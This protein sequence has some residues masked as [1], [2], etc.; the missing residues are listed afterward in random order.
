M[1][2]TSIRISSDTHESVVKARGI[3]EQLFRRRL[4]LDEA[5]Y[6][7]SWLIGFL[8]Q[9][10]RKLEAQNIIEI[11][12]TEKGSLRLEGLANT[13]EALPEFVKEITEIQSKLD[14]RKKESSRLMVT[15]KRSRKKNEVDP[16]D[17]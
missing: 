16:D 13:I 14:N 5:V 17:W 3:L 11:I 15:T 2:S 4:S 8:Y 12:E 1:T 9:T 6:L 7:S 10:A